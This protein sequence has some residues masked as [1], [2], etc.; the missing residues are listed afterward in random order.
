M[1]S[2]RGKPIVFIPGSVS[3]YRT[4]SQLYPTLE[5]SYTCFV[6]SRRFQY[7]SIYPQ[8]GS[9]TIDV[10]TKDI[11]NFI[12]ENDLRD[13]T[14][15]GHSFGGFLALH[16][17]AQL[18]DRV[19]AVVAE[20]PIFTPV[21]MP[22]KSMLGVLKLVL[23]D[24]E[25]GKSLIDLGVNGMEPAFKALTQGDVKAAKNAIITGLTAG[26]KTP[27]TLD[28]LTRIQ[29]DDNIATLIDEDPF[30]HTIHLREVTTLQA[31]VL[32]ISGSDSQPVFRYINERLSEIIPKAKM[33]T[34]SGAGHWVHIDQ[35]T[36]FEAAV[37]EFLK[38][39]IPST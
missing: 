21:L 18:P 6:L 1:N 9:N 17:A 26:K 32:L 23:K 2:G 34:I 19:T 3:D 38:I 27:A 33:Q 13:V 22:K 14:L 30:N 25:A 16:I 20:E 24:K 11:I 5:K 12:T 28:T 7:P 29:L 8:D 37:V 39:R 10:N 35:A 4:W 31:R 15:I 36:R